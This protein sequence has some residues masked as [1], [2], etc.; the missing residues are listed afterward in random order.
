LETGAF[1]VHYGRGCGTQGICSVPDGKIDFNRERVRQWR[2]EIVL[3]R[4]R[5]A[6]DNLSRAQRDALWRVVD[7]R[8]ASLQALVE[9]FPA[10]LE[11]I[12][13]EIEHELRRP[14]A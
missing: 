7:F 6:D 10:E 2:R 11:R 8:E 12:D 4:I 3:A 9:D 13:R 1:P 14:S 5:L